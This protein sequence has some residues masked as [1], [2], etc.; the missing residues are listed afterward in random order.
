MHI[1][2]IMSRKE[3]EER[4]KDKRENDRS[5]QRIRMQK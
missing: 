3:Q 4:D 5:E 2:R 1:C